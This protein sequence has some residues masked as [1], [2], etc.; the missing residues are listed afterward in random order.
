MRSARIGH[1]RENPRQPVLSSR[2]TSL[3]KE[4]SQAE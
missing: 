2:G 1:S 4:L 3:A